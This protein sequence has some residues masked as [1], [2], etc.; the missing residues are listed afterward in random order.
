MLRETSRPHRLGPEFFFLFLFG[1]LFGFFFG[2]FF[3]FVGFF[4]V[5]RFVFVFLCFF[6]F[7][8]LF[9]DLLTDKVQPLSRRS[10]HDERHVCDVGGAARAL[11]A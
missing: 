6:C 7:F 4:Q 11:F 5:S 10:R 8:P 2:F 3:F 9:I 1:F